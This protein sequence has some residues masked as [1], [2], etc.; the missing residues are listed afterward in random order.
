[1]ANVFLVCGGEIARLQKV[2]AGWSA[3]SELNI[4]TFNKDRRQSRACVL[5]SHCRPR[6]TALVMRMVGEGAVDK[7]HGGQRLVCSLKH[8]CCF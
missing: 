8:R 5:V 4:L 1:M 6:A 7:L 3:E 2:T